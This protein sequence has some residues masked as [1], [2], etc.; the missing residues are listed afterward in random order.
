[1]Q[2]GGDF[3]D[4]R[5]HMK[6]TRIGSLA[7]AMSAMIFSVAASAQQASS[8]LPPGVIA[9]QGGVDV[10]L[11]D[12]DAYAQR[13]PEKDRAGFFNNAQRIENMILNLLL[14]RQLSNEARSA[15]LDKNPDVQRQ[16]NLAEEDTLARV[17]LQRYRKD[18]KLPNF[19]M[20]AKEYY[21]AHQDEFGPPTARKTFDEVRE[22][23]LKKLRDSYI[24]TQV[25]QFTGDFRGKKLEANP[26]L[27]ASL[28]TRFL[29]AGAALPSDAADQEPAKQ[30]TANQNKAGGKS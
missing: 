16:I 14:Q 22:A 2:M 15:K 11:Q 26:D 19:E 18:L 20:L 29:P 24:E 10:T 28:R 8:D 27:V 5:N 6:R 21:A 12:V 13:I 4:M 17:Y 9:R 1:M 23:L 30:K 3:F 7:I 25:D